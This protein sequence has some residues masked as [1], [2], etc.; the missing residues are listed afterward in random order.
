[1]N[2]S[3]ASGVGSEEADAVTVQ[4]AAGAVVVPGGSWVGVAGE[5]LG[6]PEWDARVQ[7]VGD[8][9]MAQ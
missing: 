8:R 2:S 7:S 5:D 9:R 3:D 1:V 6:I 4:V